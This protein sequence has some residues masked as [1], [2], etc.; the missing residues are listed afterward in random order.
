MALQLTAKVAAAVITM[1]A[2][3]VAAIIVGG[4]L[5]FGSRIGF[6]H[7]VIVRAA[8]MSSIVLRMH[9]LNCVTNRIVQMALSKLDASV[10]QDFVDHLV[11]IR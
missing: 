4:N 2:A 10:S 5:V 8:Q 1:V 11:Q 7:L 9:A 3:V 6:G